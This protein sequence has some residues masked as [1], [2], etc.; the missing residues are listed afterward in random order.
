MLDTSLPLAI[1][2]IGILLIIVGLFVL[3]RTGGGK[4]VE[5]EYGAVIVIGPIPIIIGSS[6]KAAL[7]A[8]VI[9]IL[10]LIL[11]LVLLI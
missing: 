7:I 1:I 5:K 2:I 8:G 6:K 9:A 4:N 10:M 3:T 11:F